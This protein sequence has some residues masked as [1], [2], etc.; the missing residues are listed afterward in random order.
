MLC[1]LAMTGLYVRIKSLRSFY[2]KYLIGISWFILSLLISS[3]NDI[4]GKYVSANISPL[5]TAFF[6]FLFGTLSLIPFIFYNGLESIK[7]SRP[8]LHFIRGLFLTIAIFL[9]I[10]GLSTSQVTTATIISFTIPIFILILAPIFLGEKVSMKLWVVTIIGLVGI[11][12]ILNPSRL[13]FNINSLLFVV[14]TILFASL[15]IINKKY[16]IKESMLSMLFYSSLVTAILGSLA[17]FISTATWQT[18]KIR[19]L[20]YLMLLGFGSNAILYCLLK[21]FRLVK[22]S[23]VA[24]FRYLELLISLGLGYAV[25]HDLPNYTAY[26]GASLII[27]CS[28]YITLQHKL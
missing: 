18:P 5:E 26:I 24:P 9:W 13:S 19:D 22:A 2:M 6:R 20:I 14:A 7:T 1:M 8:L 16:I 21:A 25:F 10:K 28:L 15:D 3:V 11:M 17:I 27:P 4:I 23:S 12:I